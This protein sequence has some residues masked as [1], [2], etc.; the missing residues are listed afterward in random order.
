MKRKA[1][2]RQVELKSALDLVGG[3]VSGRDCGLSGRRI[4][5]NPDPLQLL[6]RTRA[7]L[8]S[9]PLSVALSGTVAVLCSPSVDLAGYLKHRNMRQPLPTQRTILR[10]G[11]G[12]GCKLQR[13]RHRRCRDK[14]NPLW[15]QL[16]CKSQRVNRLFRSLLLCS[17]WLDPF[18]RVKREPCSP[19]RQGAPLNFL[20]LCFRCWYTTGCGTRLGNSLMFRINLA[21]CKTKR[22]SGEIRYALKSAVNTDVLNQANGGTRKS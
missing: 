3:F 16:V 8:N 6:P 18:I 17:S 4:A 21:R 12:V 13:R 11:G 19:E 7:N 2:V 20:P 9:M 10:I 15:R 22:C 5:L 1:V 14:L